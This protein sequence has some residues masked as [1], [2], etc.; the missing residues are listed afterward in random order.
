MVDAWPIWYE[1]HGSGRPLVLL[2]GG[3]ATNATWAAQI[4][5]LSQHRRVIAVE[6]S[7][8]GHTPD[9]DGPLSY[10]QMTD[11]TAEFLGALGLSS[12]DVLGWSDGGMVAFL[13]AA[14]Y[15][16]L[17]GTLSLTG[18]G[19]SSEG[20]V[21]G[22]IQELIALEAPDPELQIYR[23]LYAAASPDG[24][25]H[26]SIVWEKIRK[27][28]GEPFDWHSQLA[29][30]AV[31]TLVIVA[32]DDYVTVGH[33][34]EMARRINQGQLAVIPGAS[35]LVPMEKPELFNRLVLDFIEQPSVASLMP[36]RR[37][38]AT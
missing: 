14:R 11:E 18:T 3:L 33:A 7:G 21:P 30:V 19:F 13:L 32:D 34:E 23:D 35:H 2:H 6:R 27:L 24:P 1:S 36:L 20:Y 15:P 29:R 8:H 37:K 17:V 38:P 28:W 16:N 9:R 5:G 12:V 25:E 22:A 10:Q 4:T 26:F 31:P